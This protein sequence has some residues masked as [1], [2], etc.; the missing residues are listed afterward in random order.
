ME[1][2]GGHVDLVIAS[3]LPQQL[4]NALERIQNAC[5]VGRQCYL[6]TEDFDYASPGLAEPLQ[7]ILLALGNQ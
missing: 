6:L 5:G 7:S 3:A 1:E 2:V 4:H